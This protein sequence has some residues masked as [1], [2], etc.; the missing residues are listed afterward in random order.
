MANEGNK[1]MATATE[2]V[3]GQSHSVRSL[4]LKV[5]EL[6]PTQSV[7]NLDTNEDAKITVSSKKYELPKYDKAIHG[8]E[9]EF[10]AAAKAAV[11]KLVQPE[12]AVVDAL[13][14]Y[15]TSESYQ[16]GKQAAL[17]NG[18][19][20]TSDLRSKIVQIMRGNNKFADY[21]ASECFS[22]WLSGYKE[23]KPGAIKILTMA[24][25]FG[26]FDL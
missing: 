12:S 15:A 4:E 26:E 13:L 17:A 9:S 18:N 6:T 23:K 11:L 1:K 5:T 25:D 21:S 8:S 24:Q 2:T 20:L 7:L 3:H 22:T 14:K 19:Y 16:A 10:L